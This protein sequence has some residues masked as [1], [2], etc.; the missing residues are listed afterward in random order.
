MPSEVLRVIQEAMGKSGTLDYVVVADK[1][2]LDARTIRGV[3]ETTSVR[4]LRKI[5][6][7]LGGKL[8][9]KIDLPPL[10]AVKVKDE[11]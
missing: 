2:G 3:G 7:G 5:A 10:G 8:V 11:P 6:A 1:A 4:T 9:I